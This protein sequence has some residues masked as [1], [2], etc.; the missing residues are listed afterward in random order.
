MS[1]APRRTIVVAGA[2][3][4]S[5]QSSERIPARVGSTW[6]AGVGRRSE[7]R[8]ELVGPFR[9]GSLPA[10]GRAKGSKMASTEAKAELDKNRSNTED[11]RRKDSTHGK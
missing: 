8:G 10:D 1:G 2:F 4:S 6:F 11:T 5:P 9:M 7:L 3:I